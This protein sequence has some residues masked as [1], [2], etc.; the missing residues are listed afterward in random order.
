M[1][2]GTFDVAAK[3][4]IVTDARLINAE[5]DDALSSAY[6]DLEQDFDHRT[7]QNEEGKAVLLDETMNSVYRA[8]QFILPPGRFAAVKRAQIESLKKR[9]AAS[10]IGEKC[11]PMEA[12][13]EA[14]QALVWDVNR[15]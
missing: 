9:N 1:F 5:Q 6:S 2:Q 10:S 12:R 14:L 15:A 8:V 3:K 13:I 11:K 7:F 4:W